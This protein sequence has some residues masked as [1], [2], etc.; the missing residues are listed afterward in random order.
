MPFFEQAHCLFLLRIPVSNRSTR[1][2]AF[3]P[4]D[5]LRRLFGVYGMDLPVELAKPDFAPHLYA[6]DTFPSNLNHSTF[7]FYSQ[8]SSVLSRILRI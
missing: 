1:T 3:V 5:L 2:Y 6:N 8:F 7:S 4:Q